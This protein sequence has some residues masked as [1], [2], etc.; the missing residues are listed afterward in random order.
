MLGWRYEVVRPWCEREFPVM[1]EYP[2]YQG[3][4]LE[5]RPLSSVAS[6]LAADRIRIYVH[7]WELG[8]G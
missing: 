4:I 5:D 6:A 7:D 3:R 2:E 8:D 1:R